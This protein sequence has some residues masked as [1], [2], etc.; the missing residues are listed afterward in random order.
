MCF[1]LRRKISL[2][3]LHRKKNTAISI[4][5]SLIINIFIFYL[6]SLSVLYIS[7]DTEDSGVLFKKIVSVSVKHPLLSLVH[8]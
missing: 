7:A 1:A 4:L 6:S 5:K 2:L 3:V 8:M